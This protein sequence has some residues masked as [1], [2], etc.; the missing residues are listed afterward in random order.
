V[1]LI[2]VEPGEICSRGIIVLRGR[3]ARHARD[4]LNV[5][6]GARVRAGAVRGP[7]GHATVTEIA[8]EA[9]TLEA[10]DDLRGGAACERPVV[11]VVLALPRP[12]VV[13]RVVQTLASL[14]VG[15]IDL[16]NS[17]RVHKSYFSTERIDPA[18]LREDLVLGCEQGATT[19]LPDIAVHPMLMTFMRETLPSNLDET[20][21][22]LIAHPRASCNLE[23]VPVPAARARTVVAIGPE[24]GWI[25]REVETFEER[26]FRAV[27][28]GP[29]VMRVEAAAVAVLA[30]LELL[31]RL[32]RPAQ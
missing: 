30:Q 16:V 18:A 28:I 5:V 19:W 26:G 15:R 13:T 3:R 12:K 21:H 10:D 11:D 32:R 23:D 6:P 1:N 2:L 4:V 9:V 7:T 25:E 27:T 17:W 29:R 31:R 22:R 14:G 8:P 20:P 24:G